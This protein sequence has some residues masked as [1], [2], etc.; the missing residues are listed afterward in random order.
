MDLSQR[1]CLWSDELRAMANEGL[2]WE[3][4]NPYAV[5][6]FQRVLRIA[7]EIFA[8]Q[9]TRDA[10]E[11]EQL[12]R[13]DMMH[14]APYP[15]GDAAIFN[16]HGEIL[17]IQ[18]KDDQLWA[19]PGG[20]FEV[21]ETPAA[22]ACREAWEET[23]VEVEPLALV[24]VYDSRLCGTRSNAHL[25]Q[26]VFLCRPREQDA[27]PILSNETLDVGWYAE[28]D[29]PPLSPGHAMRIAD[30]FRC[31]RGELQGAVFDRI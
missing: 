2:Y 27:Q 14:A 9:D 20:G 21:G 24:G 1:L 16:A 11:I 15:C 17:L 13:G 7:A 4:D 19:M 31:W 6:R 12:Y 3:R 8:A 22:G 25:Y 26:F 30:A 23:G 5:R 29:L 28:A 18:R 10:K